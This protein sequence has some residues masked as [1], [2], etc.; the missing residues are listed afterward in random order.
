MTSKLRNPSFKIGLSILFLSILSCGPKPRFYLQ[1]GPEL[2]Q[3]DLDRVL[4]ENPLAPNENIKIATLGNGQTVSNHIVQV[5]DREV[6]H[7]HKD[8]DLTVMVVKGQGYLIL[9]KER[10]D[11]TVGDVLFIPRGAVHYF[12][13]TYGEPS[14]A[15]AIF[16]PPFDGK[17]TIPSSQP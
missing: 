10:L 8:H 5:R 3:F 13:N 1:Y 16:S 2:R 7:I 11:L 9:E 17:D 12:V 6:P 14:V 15:L 4:A